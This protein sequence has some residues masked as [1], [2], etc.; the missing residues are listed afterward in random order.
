[1]FRVDQ[2]NR[3]QED[4]IGNCAVG[5]I[6]YLAS[7]KVRSQGV[8]AEISGEVA[9]GWQ[10]FAGYTFNTLKFLDDTEVS[11]TNFGRTVT[12]KHILRLWSD[13]RLPGEWSAWT[14]GAG[15]NFQTGSYTETRSVKVSQASY[16]IWN[17]RIG[18][19][20]NKNWSAALNVNN[21]FDKTYYQ[22]IGAPGWGSFYGDPR[23]ATLT[24]RGT[25]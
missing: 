25:F 7:G 2:K 8:D 6:C 12:P 10:L 3:A 9:R 1:L 24:V 16:A 21:L 17:A 23:N 13:Y 4:L 22:T 5:D 14:L 15:V 11:N 19:Q 20:F 18:Y